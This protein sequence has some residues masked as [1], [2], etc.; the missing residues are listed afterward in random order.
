MIIKRINV[1]HISKVTSILIFSNPMVYVVH[2]FSGGL[3]GAV[4]HVVYI[5]VGFVIYV[6]CGGVCDL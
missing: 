3:I 4:V 6:V 2:V 5:E 1:K